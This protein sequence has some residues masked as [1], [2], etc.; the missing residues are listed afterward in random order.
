M[1]A[2]KRGDL[3]GKA[4]VFFPGDSGNLRKGERA[5]CEKL[6]DLIRFMLLFGL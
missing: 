3:G 6:E 2:Q 4:A 1:G 5:A